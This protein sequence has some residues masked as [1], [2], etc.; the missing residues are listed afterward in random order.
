L[1]GS[2]QVV[3]RFASEAILAAG[4]LDGVDKAFSSPSLNRAAR[5]VQSTRNLA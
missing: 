4:R 2:E 1:P 3:Q 5:H